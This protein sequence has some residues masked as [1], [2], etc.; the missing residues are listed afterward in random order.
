MLLRHIIGVIIPMISPIAYVT[1]F[2]LNCFIVLFILRIWF[3]ASGADFY[4]KVSRTIH[5]ATRIPISFLGNKT[6]HQINLS[7]VSII[8]IL[9]VI[10]YSLEYFVFMRIPV[11]EI[12]LPLLLK[13]FLLVIKLSGIV[14]F[15]ALFLDAI[16]S[17]IPGNNLSLLTSSL[18][19]PI[20]NE[21]R[22]VI[23]RFGMID[24]S[25]LIVFIL[26]YLADYLILQTLCSV[27][28]ESLG[29][30]LWYCVLL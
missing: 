30:Y 14:F 26:L 28:N 20:L 4:N 17:W 16:L 7:A 1:C 10:K 2:V 21:V 18:V 3:Q 12:E 5:I 19:N 29:I 27:F 13:P 22:R 25:S 11:E 23:P 8:A 24:L 6:W 9:L 15:F